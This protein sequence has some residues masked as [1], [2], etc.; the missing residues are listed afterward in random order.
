MSLEILWKSI[1]R[2]CYFLKSMLDV[3]WPFLKWRSEHGRRRR[4]IT[5]TSTRCKQIKTGRSSSNY[6]K[7]LSRYLFVAIWTFSIIC[8]RLVIRIGTE[9]ALYYNSSKQRLKRIWT[10][11]KFCCLKL[12]IVVYTRKLFYKMINGYDNN[13]KKS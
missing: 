6:T 4:R 10:T 13:W 5:T 8:A 12:I 2:L 11:L 1:L 3:V 9:N 7:S